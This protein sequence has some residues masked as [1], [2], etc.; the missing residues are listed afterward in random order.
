MN[1]ENNF[2]SLHKTVEGCMTQLNERQFNCPPPQQNQ[3]GLPFPSQPQVW[4]RVQLSPSRQEA[5]S[6]HMVA[7]A[8]QL[9]RS[10]HPSAHDISPIYRAQ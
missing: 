3:L 9:Q 8:V 6:Q 1:S 7:V 2:K 4:F 10:E 5:D